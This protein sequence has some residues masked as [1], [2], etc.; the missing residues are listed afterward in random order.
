MEITVGK[1]LE[2]KSTVI[3]DK[4]YLDKLLLS[5]DKVSYIDSVERVMN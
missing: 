5:L 4:E 1:L 2:G 3:K